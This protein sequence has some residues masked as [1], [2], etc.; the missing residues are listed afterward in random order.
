MDTIVEIPGSVCA[1]EGFSAAGVTAGIKESG[2][3]DLALI[4]SDRRASAAGVFTT[5]RL[6]AAPVLVSREHIRDGSASAIVVNSG[7][8]NA[9]T[10]DQGLADAR[11]MAHVSGEVLGVPAGSVLVA[12]TG[13]IGHALPM[14][15]VESGIRAAARS[16]GRDGSHAARAIMTTDT[17][18]KE[19]AV[20]IRHGE[21]AFRLGGIAKGVGMIGPK[22]ATLLGFVTTDA[23]VWPEV[24]QSSLRAAVE[25]SFNCITV[26]GDMSTNDTVLL[27]ANG[28]SGVQIGPGSPLHTAFAAGLLHVCTHLA[29]ELA[30]DGEGATKLI[31]IEVLGARSPAQ[32]RLVAMT[33]ANSPLFKTAIFGNDPNWG[34][35][36]AAA[37]RSGV[38]VDPSAMTLHLAGIP[39]A[40]AGQ[41]LPFDAAAARSALESEEVRV[42]LDLGQGRSSA[43]VWTCDFSYDYVRINAEY[44]T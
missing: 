18:P 7:N 35:A 20:E 8:A 10:G 26:D 21:S 31:E 2:Q 22:M 12:S 33:M 11:R 44:H 13:V 32:A 41:A 1:S 38:P 28:A 9:C 30:R 16:L 36:L 39:V 14:E 40:R 27:L 34:R 3:P 29:R 6:V 25:R 24:L 37:G 15:R 17:R 42:V 19:I 43:K 4:V 5:N 23:A